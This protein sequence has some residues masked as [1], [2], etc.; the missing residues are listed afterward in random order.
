MK[1]TVTYTFN[2]RGVSHE[3]SFPKLPDKGRGPEQDELFIKELKKRRFHKK[4]ITKCMVHHPT[5]S[6][7]L[8]F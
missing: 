2:Y 8:I 7:G 3:I 5:W 6:A 4:Y 1:N